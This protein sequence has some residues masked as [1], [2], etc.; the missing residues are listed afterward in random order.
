MDNISDVIKL[1]GKNTLNVDEYSLLSEM[2]LAPHQLFCRWYWFKKKERMLLY[3]SPGSGKTMTSMIIAKLMGDTNVI[4]IGSTTDNI[5]KDILKHPLLGFIS[6]EDYHILNGTLSDYERKILTHKLYRKMKF[7][8]FGYQEFVN[9]AFNGSITT[10]GENIEHLIK[11]KIITVNQ[12]FVNAITDKTLIIVDEAHNIYNENSLNSYG[13]TIEYVTKQRNNKLILL[14][15]TPINNNPKEIYNLLSLLIPDFSLEEASIN[16]EL[17]IRNKLPTISYNKIDN[18]DYPKVIYKGESKGYYCPI[19]ISS[20]TPEVFAARKKYIKVY[21]YKNQYL[22]YFSRGI[23]Q[24]DKEVIFSRD[25]DIYKLLDQQL[26]EV[27]EKSKVNTIGIVENGEVIK[28]PNTLTGG[29]FYGWSTLSKIPMLKNIISKGKCFIYTKYVQNQLTGI[30]DELD[31]I[32]LTRYNSSPKTNAICFECGIK[33]SLHKNSKHVFKPKYY[34]SLTGSIGTGERSEI[35]TIFNSPSNVYG[36]RI[37]TIIGSSVLEEGTELLNVNDVILMNVPNNISTLI[38]IIGRC[39]RNGSH[40]LLPED[41]RY[42]NVHLLVAQFTVKQQEELKKEYKLENLEILSPDESYILKNSLDYKV[43]SNIETTMKEISI[44]NRSPFLKDNEIYYNQLLSNP[45]K[46]R[47]N[48]IINNLFDEYG[49][50]SEDMFMNKAKGIVNGMNLEVYSDYFLKYIF[51]LF[52]STDGYQIL[53][54]KI[55]TRIQ[56]SE[57]NTNIHFLHKDIGRR[58]SLNILKDINSEKVKL[59]F[60]RDINLKNVK[61]DSLE[62]LYDKVVPIF[63]SNEPYSRYSSIF[64]FESNYSKD[65]KELMRSITTTNTLSTPYVLGLEV[66]LTFNIIDTSNIRS[67]KGTNCMFIKKGILLK[68]I[69]NTIKTYKKAFTAADLRFILDNVKKTDLPNMCQ[70]VLSVFLYAQYIMSDKMSFVILLENL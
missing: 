48:A 26:L 17:Y 44:E 29:G 6:K 42:V 21:E 46:D 35:K 61:I 56:G 14:T 36:E 66:D 68:V 70:I 7:R 52:V 15:A 24:D 69:E 12:N 50:V 8:F 22:S 3:H 20:I 41:K 9:T 43:I 40:R 13:R 2:Y 54:N 18:I 63:Y 57:T 10:D 53:D 67:S 37:H 28:T 62:T 55:Y 31:S 5:K 64:Q 59:S 58:Q 65:V 39:V 4:V 51:Y 30:Q 32:G 25:D 38:Q 34:Y 1:N 49:T 11:N 27:D 33:L 60:Y 16:P 23:A 19:S 47:V 45:L